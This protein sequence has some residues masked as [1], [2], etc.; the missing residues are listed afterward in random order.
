M[1]IVLA[2]AG[3]AIR[4][5]R[6]LGDVLGDVAGLAIDAAVRPG[7]RIA[8]LR[9]VIEAP[10]CPTVRIVA[11][12]AIRSEP[13][14]M[15]PVA[16]AGGASQ[17]RTFEQQRPMTFFAGYDGV[18]TDQG[19][20]SDVVIERRHL[21]PVG[22]SV[23]LLAAGAELPFVAVVFAVAGYA[24]RRQLVAI[25]IAGVAGVAL[26]CRV[27]R[28][29]RK[30][31]HLVVVEADR[32]PLVLVVAALALAAV[33]SG[34][35]ILNLVAIDA[36]SADPL[37]VFAAMARRAGDGAVRGLEREFGRVVVERLRRPPGCLA[38]AIVAPLAEAPFVAI[39]RLMTVEAA[40][41]R[42]AVFCRL[43]VTAVTLR[44]LV[45]VSELEI[46]KRVIERLAIELDD[47]GIPPLVVGVTARAVLPRRIRLTPVKSPGQ[48]TVRG[49]FLVACEA[50]PGLRP[51]RERLVAVGAVLLE[52]FMPADERPRYDQLF[53]HV[54]RT[55]CPRHCACQNDR[56][57]ERTY[58]TT[59]QWRASIQKKCAA[60]T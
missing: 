58:E 36:R 31:R 38:M 21:A 59:P 15:M 30:L 20:S 47:V 13:A 11:E 32:A 14:F 27:R 22:F 28:P 55:H 46:R 48:L 18:T 1:R 51:S 49:D 50:E 56:D 25:K 8:C 7:Q 4:G 9:V 29:E 57:R 5:Q 44:G 16:V 40:P 23:A 41:G 10:S 33:P 42:V 45:R 6:N 26:D 37:V 52:L 12:R 19:K 3:V 34:V 60:K 17:R 24:G 43:R 39:V 2:V 53:E 35:D 54:L